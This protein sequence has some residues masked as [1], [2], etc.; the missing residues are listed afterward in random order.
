[1]RALLLRIAK[2]TAA[3][4]V[5]CILLFVAAAGAIWGYYAMK[6]PPVESVRGAEALCGNTAPVSLDTLPRHVIDAIVAAEDPEFWSRRSIPSI[7][8]LTMLV[9]PASRGNMMRPS[10]GVR[11][12]QE[13]LWTDFKARR[14]P[15]L[16]HHIRSLV[17]SDRVELFLPK[18]VIAEVYLNAAYFGQRACGLR[19][20]AETYFGKTPEILEPAESAL[21]A[22]MIRGPSSY[23]PRHHPEK[24]LERRNMILARMTQQGFLTAEES[25]SA[26]RA[27]LGIL[28][29]PE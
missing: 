4:A 6:L 1:M 12:A 26:Q 5:M 19:Q 14:G 10:L 29:P 11:V 28:P 16:E 25:E 17:Q 8:I 27:D 24:A 9:D 21:L 22:A 2:I 23:D 15:S 18:D 13:I 7:R 20:A 3:S